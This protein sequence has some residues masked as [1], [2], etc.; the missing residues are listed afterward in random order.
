MN[1][2]RVYLCLGSNLGDRRAHLACG[3]RALA[4]SGVAIEVQSRIY[5]TEP[6]DVE[7][8]PWF[9][10]QVV[11]GHT[12]LPP[13]ALRALCE[14]VE[15]ACGRQPTFRYGPRV[16]DIDIL[17]Y[18]DRVIEDPSL[19]VPHPRLAERRFMLEPL[20][21]IAPD[22]RDPRD[23]APYREKLNGLDGKKVTPLTDQGS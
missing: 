8:Q 1:A 17:L 10:N 9:L 20:L 3:R 5:E 12:E 2:E 11:G 14:R 16:L 21:E 7:D 6:T 18:A 13:H 4:Q 15:T 23:G 19:Q 22:A